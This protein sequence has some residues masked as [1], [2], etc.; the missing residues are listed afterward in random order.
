MNKEGL[1][2][3]L[4]GNPIDDNSYELLVLQGLRALLGDVKTQMAM[5]DLQNSNPAACEQV[6]AEAQARY[7]ALSPEQKENPKKALEQ[8]VLY[9]ECL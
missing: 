4:A 8:V 2:K 1:V 9:F 3:E 5:V 6:M 7:D